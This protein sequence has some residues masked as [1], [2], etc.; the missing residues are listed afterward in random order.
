MPEPTPAD[1]VGITPDPVAP[2]PVWRP[3]LRS[4]AA[5]CRLALLGRPRL[6]GL[7]LSADTFWIAT[8]VQLALSCALAFV[9]AELPRR[10]DAHGLASEG[11][12]IALTLFLSYLI[13]SAFWDAQLLWRAATL[14]TLAGL[15]TGSVGVLV[16]SGLLPRWAEG[17]SRWI[18]AAW[19]V[20]LFWWLLILYR[21]LELL[22]PDSLP[23]KRYGIASLCV[24]LTALCTWLVPNYRLWTTDYAA[25]YEA[26]EGNRPAPLIAE[27]IFAQQPALMRQALDRVA[28]GKP[29]KPELYFVAFGPYGDQDVFRKEAEYSTQLFRRRFAADGRTLTLVNN[30]GSIAQLPLATVTNLGQALNAIGRRMNVEEDILFLFMTSHG[31]QDGTLAV[32]LE[33]LSFSDFSA[34]T[35]ARLLRDSGIRWKVLVVSGC[36]S[37]SFIKALKDERSLLITAA[38]D[39]RVSFGCSDGAEFTHFGRAYFEQA[40]NQSTS[41][42]EAFAIAKKQVTEWERKDQEPHSEP[43][44]VSGKLIEAKLAAWRATL[45]KTPVARAPMP[46]P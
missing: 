26:E 15:V 37:G 45:P 9:S 19:G 32:Q 18:W 24:A 13:A 43:Q 2:E 35:L 1:P 33:N 22:Q 31:S 3:L 38:R 5:G 12:G 39:D 20:F 30:R 40:L 17:D 14:I 29:G 34:D 41:F 23:G 4:L 21:L 16:Q 8:A 44:I 27:E 25:L 36:Y 11:L 6:A 28:A 46:A 10:F 7:P 42:T